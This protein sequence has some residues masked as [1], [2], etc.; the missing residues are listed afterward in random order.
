MRDYDHPENDAQWC[1]ERREEVAAYLQREGVVHGHIGAA[2]AWHVA[3]YVSVWAIESLATAGAVGWW[4]V[5][6][7]LPNDYVSASHAKTPREAVGAIALLWKEAAQYMSRGEPHPTF[8]IGSGLQDAELAPM[9]E[10]RAET[11]L[12]WVKDPEV[13]EEGAA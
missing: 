4:A 1:A 12:E 11:L 5:S 2:P 6:G 10:S 8:R 7:D 9:L 13:W 3:P